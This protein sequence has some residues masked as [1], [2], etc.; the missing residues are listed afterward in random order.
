MLQKFH[1]P[2]KGG[3]YMQFL[4]AFLLYCKNS[5]H[6]RR[7]QGGRHGMTGKSRGAWRGA[8]EGA[9]AGRNCTKFLAPYIFLPSDL[10]QWSLRLSW[11]TEE[12]E[13]QKPSSSLPWPFCLN[14]VESIHSPGQFF[15]TLDILLF[16]EVKA[17]L[18]RLRRHQIF[19]WTNNDARQ[20]KTRLS[21]SS[22][23]PHK[24]KFMAKSSKKWSTIFPFVIIIQLN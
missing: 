24:M 4:S 19:V 2:T 1:W 12:C 21:S 9:Q 20:K 7:Q 13:N 15:E 16:F 6:R 8:K 3:R 14:S 18:T 22:K 11:W 17:V 10:W 5:V 23:K